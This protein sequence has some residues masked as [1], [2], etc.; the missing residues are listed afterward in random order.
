MSTRP[1][2]DELFDFFWSDYSRTT[3][4]APRIHALLEGR[5]ER[6]VNDHVAFRTFNVR[7]IE[8]ESLATVFARRGYVP[9]GEYRFDEKKLRAM[10]FRHP[11]PGRPHVF[12]S[13]LLSEEFSRELQNA[14]RG[15]AEQVPD[16]RWGTP[17]L[18][19]ALPTWQPVPYP[20]YRR[21]LEESEYAGWVSAFGIRVNHFTVSVDAL[22]TFDGLAALNAFLVENGFRMNESGGTIKGTPAELLEQSS[23]L[24]SR[25]EWEFAGGEKHVI[26]SCYYEFARRYT[27]PSTG[28]PYS[29]FIAKSADRIFESTDTKIR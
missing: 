2:L 18:F 22:E 3:P 19:T 27:D 11:E 21:L 26:P 4:D 10:S 8:L 20:V 7:P 1:T 14:V 23:I 5:G 24:A 6:V 13:E 15:L 9:T 17:E 28:E 16:D 29:G 25:I 12:V